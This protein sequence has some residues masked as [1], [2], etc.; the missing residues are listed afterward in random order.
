M[1]LDLCVREFLCLPTLLLKLLPQSALFQN[2]AAP[3]ATSLEMRLL[4]VLPNGDF[5]LTRPF[6]DAVPDYAILSHTWGDDSQ[7]LTF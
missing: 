7:E 3:S 5:C 1:R 2:L 4:K 6:L